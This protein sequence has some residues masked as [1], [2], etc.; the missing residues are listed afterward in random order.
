MYDLTAVC[1]IRYRCDYDMY[2]LIA[3]HSLRY[4]CDYDIYD[5]TAVCSTKYWCDYDLHPYSCLQRHYMWQWPIT[6]PLSAPTTD[7]T[8]TYDLTDV[9]IPSRPW[10]VKLSTLCLSIAPVQEPLT[11]CYVVD[12]HTHLNK[13]KHVCRTTNS[14]KQSTYKQQCTTVHTYIWT[15][16]KTHKTAHTSKQRQTHNWRT[17]HTVRQ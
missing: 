7:V 1:S 15:V 10:T 12:P 11:W 13:S 2:D 16:A 9:C 17:I 5:P 6:S 4:R 3:V 14:A 8:I